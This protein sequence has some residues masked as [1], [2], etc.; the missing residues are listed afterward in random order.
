[1]KTTML[2]WIFS[3][4]WL[5]LLAGLVI[6]GVILMV[7]GIQALRKYIRSKPG[8][9][10]EKNVRRSLAESIRENRQRCKMTQE[11]VA[12]S[13]HV[14][15]QAVSKWENGMSEPSTANLIAL[16]ELFGV[17]VDEMINK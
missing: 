2:F 16:A 1:M 10:Y 17:S 11:F 7:L 12:E 8:N 15:R 13:L 4:M 9:E 14:S 5:L 6:G 3:A